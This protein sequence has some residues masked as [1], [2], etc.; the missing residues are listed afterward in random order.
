MRNDPVD[1]DRADPNDVFV[2][3]NGDALSN[4]RYA[5][6][7]EW[8]VFL[9]PAWCSDHGRFDDALSEAARLAASTQRALWLCERGIIVRVRDDAAARAA[10][11][12]Q[13]SRRRSDVAV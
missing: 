11:S 13:G 2:Y 4:L 12:L 10:H 9:G 1:R 5:S 8:S 3:A 7:A 6:A